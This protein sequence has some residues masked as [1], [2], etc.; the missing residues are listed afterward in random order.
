[1]EHSMNQRMRFFRPGTQAIVYGLIVLGVL[2]IADQLAMPKGLQDLQ[3]IIGDAIGAAIVGV[4]VYWYERSRSK[5]LSEKLT[6]IELM[7]HHVRNAL[8]VI[9]DSVY[10]ACSA[11]KRNPGRD[12][13]N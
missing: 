10:I 8:Q 4:L 9:A 5:Y 11:N 13:A 7:N 2:M 6:T 12:Q 3:L 1:M